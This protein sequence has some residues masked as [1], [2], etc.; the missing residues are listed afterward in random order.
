MKLVDSSGWLE[1]FTGGTLASKYAAHLSNLSAVLTPTVVLYEVYKKVRRERSEEEALIVAAQMQKT[2]LV[3]L[4]ETLA[5]SAAEISIGHRLAMADAIV[6]ATAL[7][8]R[9][10]VV[11]SDADLRKLTGVTYLAKP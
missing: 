10:E 11:T 5:L 7:L 6:Y 2:F 9:A 4:S 3:P 8:H 1:F